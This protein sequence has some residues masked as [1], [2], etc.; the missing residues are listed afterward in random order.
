MLYLFVLA[1][2]VQHTYTGQDEHLVCGG[3]GLKAADNWSYQASE[4]AP[5]QN[6]S[7]N[8]N[9]NGRYIIVGS[10]LIIKEVRGSDAGIYTCGRGRQL[11][12]K[13]QLNVNGL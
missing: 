1:A 12:H 5:R 9:D 13:L 3:M 4:N 2:S 11:Y 10:C 6:L 7:V 8:G